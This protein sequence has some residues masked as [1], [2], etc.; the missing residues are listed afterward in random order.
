M[1]TDK[2][3]KELKEKIDELVGQAKDASEEVREEMEET[4][5]ALKKQREKLEEKMV[6][7]KTKNEPKIEEAKHHLKV[8]GEE[9]GKAFEKLFRKGP[10][11]H[12][13]K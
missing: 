5:E 9:I 3:L 2:I 7:F 11:A 4:I 8:A 13:E 10:S 1:D 12:E 6:D